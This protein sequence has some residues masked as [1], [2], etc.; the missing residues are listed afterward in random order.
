MEARKIVFYTNA[1]A[2]AMFRRV[3]LKKRQFSLKMKE[4]YT[5]HAET[6]FIEVAY[7]MLLLQLLAK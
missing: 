3:T 1:V 4:K 7:T 6:I 2:Y 5:V